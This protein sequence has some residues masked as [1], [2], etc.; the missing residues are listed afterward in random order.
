MPNLHERTYIHYTHTVRCLRSFTPHTTCLLYLHSRQHH[1]RVKW[2]T[3]LLSS[4]LSSSLP[5]LPPPLPDLADLL[6]CASSSFTAL[7]AAV[8]VST[9]ESSL[10]IALKSSKRA[11]N[12]SSKVPAA[13]PAVLVVLPAGHGL[14]VMPTRTEGASSMLS[15]KAS[16]SSISPGNPLR[17]G[18][19]KLPESA[20]RKSSK[21]TRS[22]CVRSVD[23]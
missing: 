6:L 14:A 2:P 10:T 15:R 20:P 16:M 22:A 23:A 9:T 19:P 18:L 1:R 7:A 17:L 12:S 4:S 13:A 8:V 21:A 11:S 5:A 3:S